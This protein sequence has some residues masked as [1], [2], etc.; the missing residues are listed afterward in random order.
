MY[1]YSKFGQTWG[2]NSGFE[3][4]AVQTG[5]TYAPPPT[6]K[7]PPPTGPTSLL[8]TVVLDSNGNHMIDSGDQGFAGVE[9]DLL[10]VN[11]IVIASTTS[12]ADGSYSFSN[13]APGTYGIQM[14][15]PTGRFV[16]MYPSTGTVG[17]NPDGNV[18]MY[19]TGFTNIQINSGDAGVG[20]N[21]GLWQSGI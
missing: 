9:V 12:A 20:Y 2:A 18:D 4:W 1:L 7:S 21:I 3:E 5:G 17:G 10:D 13:L 16:N 14:V 8:G 11:G 15:A 6:I 19:W